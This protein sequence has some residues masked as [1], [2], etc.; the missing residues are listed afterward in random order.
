M[1]K[2]VWGTPTKTRGLP[3]TEMYLSPEPRPPEA[4][5]EPFWEEEKYVDPRTPEAVRRYSL[6]GANPLMQNEREKMRKDLYLHQRDLEMSTSQREV[7]LDKTIAETQDGAALIED[8][9]VEMDRTAAVR[10][11]MQAEKDTTERDLENISDQV[12]S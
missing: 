5:G 6:H 1:S 10:N 7:Q 3:A 12:P 8:I 11:A 9:G 4:S 2:D